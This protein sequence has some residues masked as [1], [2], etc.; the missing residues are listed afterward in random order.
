M[1]MRSSLALLALQPFSG[2]L[3]AIQ[4]P[5]GDPPSI[6]PIGLSPSSSPAYLHPGS[7]R[8]SDHRRADHDHH[9][10]ALLAPHFLECPLTWAA[11]RCSLLCLAPLEAA[12]APYPSVWQNTSTARL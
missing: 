7:R 3:L 4:Y 2:P 6:A 1:R 11:T 8:P 9:P 5:N 10:R 12:R